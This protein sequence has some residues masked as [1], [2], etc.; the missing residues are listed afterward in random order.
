MDGDPG[1]GELS[2]EG[3]RSGWFSHAGTGRLRGHGQSA[4]NLEGRCWDSGLETC[5]SSTLASALACH[6]RLGT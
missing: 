4:L 6:L 1:I 5:P 2:G 3:V